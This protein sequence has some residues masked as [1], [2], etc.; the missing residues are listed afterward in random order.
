MVVRSFFTRLRIASVRRGLRPKAASS[1]FNGSAI[2]SAT[3]FGLH[4]GCFVS[5]GP[6]SVA[7]KRSISSEVLRLAIFAARSCLRIF[8]FRRS[9]SKSYSDLYRGHD[10]VLHAAACIR[11]FNRIADRIDGF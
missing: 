10:D 4:V 9:S 5:T 1:L 3:A 8:R 7:I 2:L 11:P 6:A